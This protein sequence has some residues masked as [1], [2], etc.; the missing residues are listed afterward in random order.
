M[1]EE[2]LY[3]VLGVPADATPEAIKRAFRT[4]AKRLHPDKP[5][6]SAARFSQLQI[7][8]D[9][10][11]NERKRAHYDAT[12][13][14]NETGGDP[15]EEHARGTI[16]LIIAAFLDRDDV[17]SLSLSAFV[18]DGLD[19]KRNHIADGNKVVNGLRDKAARLRKA[20]S[21]LKT[22]KAEALVVAIM[23]RTIDQVEREANRIAAEVKEEQLVIERAAAIFEA[24]E[25]TYEPDARAYG[26]S[27]LAAY[28][29]PVGGG[30]GAQSLS[31]IL[32]SLI[33]QQGAR[34]R[35]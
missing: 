4:N 32:D 18:K 34:S 28:G 25:Y 11:R 2:N 29:G 6:G 22:P 26:A 17:L 20:R 13:K 5:G 21:K 27:P 3:D 23:E 33:R 8:Y 1:T 7:A 31:E 24:G 14:I 35:R 15:V 30:G 9:T 16:G 12:G 19:A 10:L